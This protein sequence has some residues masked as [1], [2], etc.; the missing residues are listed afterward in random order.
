MSHLLVD[1]CCG[2]VDGDGHQVQES[3]TG[4]APDVRGGAG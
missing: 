4:A 1:V 3:V 2:V